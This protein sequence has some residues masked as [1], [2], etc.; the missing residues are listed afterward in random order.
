MYARGCTWLAGAGVVLTELVGGPPQATRLG[1]SA[2]PQAEHG[3][4]L[5]GIQAWLLQLSFIQLRVPKTVLVFLVLVFFRSSCFRLS[6][7]FASLL[8]AP[9]DHR[10]HRLRASRRSHHL[11]SDRSSIAFHATRPPDCVVHETQRQHSR[12]AR[13]VEHLALHLH[14]L[15]ATVAGGTGVAVS[16]LARR[17]HPRHAA[18]ALQRG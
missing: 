2:D 5:G 1:P 11:C 9:T 3:Q 17:V 7:L 6:H 14:Q 8:P 18:H 12:P 13:R 10:D 15:V 4:A 16:F